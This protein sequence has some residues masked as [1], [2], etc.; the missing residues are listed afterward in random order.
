M[1]MRRTARPALITAPM[2]YGETEKQR[3]TFH[4]LSAS[5]SACTYV[6]Y[7]LNYYERYAHGVPQK[8]RFWRGREIEEKI[9][10]LLP[11]F[12]LYFL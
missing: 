6:V 8:S 11:S 2:A 12:L 7:L 3:M 5:M 9:L 4:S 10:C 1:T